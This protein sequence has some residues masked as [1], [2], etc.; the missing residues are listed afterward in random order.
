MRR[1]GGTGTARGTRTF[2]FM[3]GGM[4]LDNESGLNRQVIP[5][6]HASSSSLS[7]S[8]S[9][10]SAGGSSMN[11]GS[12]RTPDD[13]PF[14]TGVPSLFSTVVS[15]TRL[16]VVIVR[17]FSVRILLDMTSAAGTDADV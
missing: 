13:S 3:P 6:M 9:G 17:R 7:L 16:V 10:M 2:G 5:R 1:G 8:T 15:R 12:S 4:A 14:T 11:A